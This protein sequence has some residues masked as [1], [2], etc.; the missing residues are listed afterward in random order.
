MAASFNNNERQVITIV[1]LSAVFARSRERQRGGT[2][3]A[4]GHPC[5]S[6]RLKVMRNA[7]Q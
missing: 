3:H 5:P 4:L 1:N 7:I 2:K 6:L